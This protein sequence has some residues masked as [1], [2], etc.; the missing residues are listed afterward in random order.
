MTKR[1]F[2]LLLVLA[3]LFSAL[4]GLWL[5]RAVSDSIVLAGMRPQPGNTMTP[6]VA[7]GLEEFN[8]QVDREPGWK[9]HRFTAAESGFS[10]E[11]VEGIFRGICTER[12]PPITW[13]VAGDPLVVTGVIYP[14]R[15]E[16][17]IQATLRVLRSRRAG[18]PGESGRR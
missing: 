7:K 15:L 18:A 8:R 16:P 13:N 12:N 11:V 1:R 4:C 2:R 14:A 5:Y 3:I 17:A 10:H 6:D 9:E